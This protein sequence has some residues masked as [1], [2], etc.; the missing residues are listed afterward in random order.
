MCM[1][2]LCNF[3]HSVFAITDERCHVFLKNQ[4]EKKLNI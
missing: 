2:I 4:Y 1:S 3:T